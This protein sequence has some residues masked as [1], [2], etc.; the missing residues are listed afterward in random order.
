MSTIDDEPSQNAI[1]HYLESD[2]PK[3]LPKSPQGYHGQKHVLQSEPFTC[4]SLCLKADEQ[5][6]ERCK[7]LVDTQTGNIR[8]PE[9]STYGILV[10]PK[11]GWWRWD[12]LHHN[13][14]ARLHNLE[15]A[16]KAMA[17]EIQMTLNPWKNELVKAIQRQLYQL[18]TQAAIGKQVCMVGHDER[19]IE[20]FQNQKKSKRIRRVVGNTSLP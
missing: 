3:R 18:P 4:N 17:V 5:I 2:D 1:S 20:H 13:G 15:D 14:E 8:P 16:V 11:T 6:R 9:P 7:E 10:P 12:M 19:K